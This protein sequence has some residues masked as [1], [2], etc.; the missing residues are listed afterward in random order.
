MLTLYSDGGGQRDSTAASACIIDSPKLKRPRKIVAYIGPGTNNEAEIIGGLLGY[1]FI[2][3][4]IS[5]G[6]PVSK[7]R[8]VCDSEYVLKSATEY[9]KSWQRNGWKTSNRK[10]VKNQSL[11]RAYLRLSAELDITPEHVR[12]HTG[13]TENEACDGAA[14]WAQ[15]HGPQLFSGDKQIVKVDGFDEPDGQAWF[16][17]NGEPFLA[18]MREKEGSELGEELCLVLVELLAS[19]K[20]GS[21]GE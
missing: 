15:M 4:M 16:A 11:W 10:P 1:S 5:R 13:H 3:L 2:R 18:K 17:I 19:F 8:W 7:V 21:V 6:H 20:N 9:I 14:T 12:G